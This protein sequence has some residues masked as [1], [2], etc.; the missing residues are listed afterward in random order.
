MDKRSEAFLDA[1][2]AARSLLGFTMQELADNCNTSK[3]NIHALVNKQQEPKLGLAI[4]LA[5]TLHLSLDNY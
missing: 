4:K 2:G 3:S 5:S 1:V